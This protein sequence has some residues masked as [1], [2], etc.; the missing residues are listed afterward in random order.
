MLVYKGFIGQVDYDNVAQ[1]LVGEVVNAVDVL[2]FSGK[3]ADEIK[4]NFQACVDDYL[5]FHKEETGVNPTPF[6]GNFMVCLATDKQRK[7]I[8]A[9][10]KEGQSISHWLNQHVNDYLADYFKN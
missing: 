2:E 7:V 10:Q 3:T 4:I 1:A 9:A 5:A 6:I 8:K